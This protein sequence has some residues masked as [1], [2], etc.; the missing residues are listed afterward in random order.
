[1]VIFVLQGRKLNCKIN[2]IKLSLNILWELKKKINLKF[3]FFCK[4]KFKDNV[5]ENR[6][7]L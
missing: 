1:M 3:K 5:Y 7:L 2:N 6:K 4:N